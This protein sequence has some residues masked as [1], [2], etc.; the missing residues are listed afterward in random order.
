[1]MPRHIPL[2]SGTTTFEDF[3]YTLPRLAFPINL[4]NGNALEKYEMKFASVTGSRYAVAFSAGRVGLYG[5]LLSYGIGK[6]DEVMLHVP[7][8]IV[9]PN[10]IRYTGASPVYVDCNLNDYNIDIKKAEEKITPRTRALI[11][12]HTFGIPADIEAV[13]AFAKTHNLIVI[14][15]CVH[16]LGGMYKGKKLGSF[17]NASFFST[18]ETKMISTTMGGIIVTDDEETAAKMKKFRDE[19]EPPGFILTYKYL[20]K[21][22]LYYLLLNPGIH[23]YTRAV[24]EFFGN[25]LPLPRPTS[26]EE[27][28]GDRPAK[29]LVRFSN[30]LAELGLRQLRRLTYN[31]RHRRK[32]ASLYLSLLRSKELKRVRVPYG[33]DPSWV[34]YPVWVTNREEANRRFRKHGVLG[35]WFSSVLEE[36]VDPAHA[37][38]KT[39]SCPNAERA[40]AHLINLPCHPRVT[41]TDASHL[42]SIIEDL[43]PN[44]DDLNSHGLKMK[45]PR[46]L[47]SVSPKGYSR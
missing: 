2:L 27:L 45:G 3:L 37:E 14:E 19:C 11:L 33:S 15:D 38:Y 12:Q 25:R 21:F 8:H 9:V 24:Y 6:G 43:V 39:G 46:I 13:L 32:I 1:M 16:A 31:L 20:L 34:R 17:G 42:I 44:E 28:I 41:E 26:Y 35:M 36:A 40:A 18:E 47:S 22:S 23:K 5:L 4:I 30:V 7:S 10:A 29:Y